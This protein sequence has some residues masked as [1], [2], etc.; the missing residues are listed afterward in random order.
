MPL[1]SKYALRVSSI[2]DDTTKEQYAD[3][4]RSVSTLGDCKKLS[5]FSSFKAKHWG[6]ISKHNLGTQEA[7][8]AVSSQDGTP[9]AR[10]IDDG[11]R[12]SFASQHGLKVGTIAFSS[13]QRSELVLERHERARG[14][15]GYPWKD[16]ELSSNFQGITVLREH[17]E[18]EEE[19]EGGTDSHRNKRAK[20]D[21]DICAVHGLGG[22][23]MDTWT[24]SS[25]GL[26]WLRD[27]LP[28]SEYFSNTRI[29]TFGYD[30][31]LT[32]PSTVAGLENWAES[33]IHCLSEVRTSK[34]ERAR[35]LLLICHSLGGLVARKAMSQLPTSNITGITLSQC[36]LVFL[37]T[38][39]TGTTKADWNSFLV[40]AAGTVVGVRPEVVSY[41]QSFNPAS[42]WDK[43][44]FL[45]LDPRPPF[46]CFAEGRKK[47][48]NGTYQHVV[49]QSS[50]SLD[51]ENPALMIPQDHSGICKFST[52]LGTYITV[53]SA[54]N[55][56]FSEVTGRL[57]PK[58]VEE[59]RVRAA[60]EPSRGDD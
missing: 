57:V 9:L 50:A 24:V 11:I 43:K 42:V 26:M 6:K 14:N 47:L 29:M 52:K 54:L 46:R 2:P 16:W 40:A 49:T 12:T 25:K 28:S 21:M 32:D 23:A 19:T 36:G 8:R 45:K 13:K 35:P 41:L 44:A 10:D 1:E 15:T 27:Y 4:V 53:S 37:A 5:I 18:T 31:D 51:P 48:I 34:E 39:H 56:V 33:L 59:H 3:F 7:S 38:P 17:E 58:Q 60:D 30:S 22:N 55:E 20:A